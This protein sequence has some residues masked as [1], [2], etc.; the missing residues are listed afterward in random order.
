MMLFY[1]NYIADLALIYRDVA[2]SQDN[3]F[4]YFDFNNTNA[5]KK[6]ICSSMYGFIS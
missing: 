4:L 5:G 3:Q 6:K 2:S 1:W